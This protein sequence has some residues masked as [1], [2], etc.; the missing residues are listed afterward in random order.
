MS[1]WSAALSPDEADILNAHLH[2]GWRKIH[3]VYPWP[4]P[5]SATDD[6]GSLWSETLG[7]LRDL[8]GRMAPAG[9]QS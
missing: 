8:N 3:A 6:P 5:L 9:S 4:S 7:L 2:S 1:A